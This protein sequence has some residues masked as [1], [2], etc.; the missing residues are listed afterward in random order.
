MLAKRTVAW[1]LVLA[2]CACPCLCLAQESAAETKAQVH[3]APCCPADNP[4]GPQPGHDS[5]P[6]STCLCGGAVMDWQ[7]R[8]ADVES[9]GATAFLAFAV[10]ETTFSAGTTAATAGTFGCGGSPFPPWVSGREIR[11]LIASFLL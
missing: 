8:A 2:L 5:L 6:V 9:D 1:P 11:A 3:A 4:S 10:P 7:A